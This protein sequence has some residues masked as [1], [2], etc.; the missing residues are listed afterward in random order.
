MRSSI[1]RVE[2]VFRVKQGVTKRCRLSWLTNSTLV[3]E[4]KSGG[5]GGT[6]IDECTEK[7]DQMEYIILFFAIF[8]II[9]GSNVNL[10]INMT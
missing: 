8:Y 1:L 3:Y 4:P 2:K 5:G 10:L 7:F 6:A 9:L